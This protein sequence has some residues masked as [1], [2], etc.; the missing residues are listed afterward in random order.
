MDAPPPAR[1]RWTI[2]RK[3]FAAFG[4]VGVGVVVV[5]AVSFTSLGDLVTSADTVGPTVAHTYE[6]M[7]AV[8]A[9]SSDLTSAETGQRGYVITGDQS[10][11]APYQ[12][13]VDDLPGRM[14]RLRSLTSDNTA[15]QE[16]LDELDLVVASKLEELADTVALNRD[17]GFQA[18]RAVITTNAGQAD[19]ASID[20]LLGQTRAAESS[21]LSERRA[22]VR[23]HVDRTRQL[24]VGGTALLLGAAAVVVWR[25]ARGIGAPVRAVTTALAALSAGDLSGRVLVRTTDET[26]VMAESLNTAT[27]NL[28]SLVEQ[29]ATTSERLATSAAGLTAQTVTMAGS[30]EQTADRA[31]LVDVAAGQVSANVQTVAA[32][33]EEMSVSIREISSNAAE[34]VR[35]AAEG[36]ECAASTNTIVRQLGISTVGVAEVVKT[37][38]AIAAQTNLLALN[39]T[40]EAARAG[41]A[42]AG[43]AVVANEVK[44]LAQET[45]RATEDIVRR[46]GTIQSDSEQAIAAISV[47]TGVI[48]RIND[49]QSTIA[50]AVEEQTATTGDMSR[51]VA[52]AAAASHEIAATIGGVATAADATRDGLISTRR[53]AEGLA[54]MASDLK[55]VLDTFHW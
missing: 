46:V 7:M 43:F 41:S 9:I 20:T 30:A 51:S 5:G 34:A 53:E 12:A 6:V 47:I 27:V 38:T 19:K 11:L 45:A 21:L 13:A 39:A 49:Y 26:A 33:S 52:E 1:L 3:L 24:I 55:G 29:V 32:G 36:A 14:E 42:G 35:V 8:D 28:R 2:A 40:I 44:E 18:A 54:L 23:G 16:R 50:A 37:I 10:Y 15:Q 17:Q 22:A 25:L 4:A 48:E 31:G